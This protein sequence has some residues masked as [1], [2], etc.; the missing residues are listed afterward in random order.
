MVE[1]LHD[2]YAKLYPQVTREA[3]I[4]IMA[5]YLSTIL[6]RRKLGAVGGH[7]GFQGRLEISFA[8]PLP[9]TPDISTRVWYRTVPRSQSNTVRP[10]WAAKGYMKVG[11]DGA[12]GIGLTTYEVVRPWVHGELTLSNGAVSTTLQADYLEEGGP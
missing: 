7:E 1:Y 10:F 9:D 6:T 8:P 12:C 3:H 5:R 4:P 2:R 11:P